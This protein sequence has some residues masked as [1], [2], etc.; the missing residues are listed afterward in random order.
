MS[1]QKSQPELTIELSM[2]IKTNIVFL[3]VELKYVLGK[4]TNMVRTICF[5]LVMEDNWKICLT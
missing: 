3:G 4:K 5:K 1:K 2:D